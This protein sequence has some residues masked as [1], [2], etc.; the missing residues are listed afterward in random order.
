MLIRSVHVLHSVIKKLISDTKQQLQQELS[1]FS[2]DFHPESK[3]LGVNDA[4]IIMKAMI[5]V[6][7]SQRAKI[8]GILASAIH[9]GFLYESG[10]GEAR[11]ELIP[12]M[13][14]LKESN[15]QTRAK[16]EVYLHCYNEWFE[17]EKSRSH[18]AL[19]YQP[20]HFDR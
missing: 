4:E 13:L 8:P 16:H 12:L 18:S 11:A 1:R 17:I 6:V 14:S 15:T 7:A 9:D 19:V 5:A 20:E 2:S 3:P 10:Y